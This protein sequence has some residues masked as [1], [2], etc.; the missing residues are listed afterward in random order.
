MYGVSDSHD[1]ELG[2]D[3]DL[4]EVMPAPGGKGAIRDEM[5]GTLVGIVRAGKRR[6]RS[7][8]TV[9]TAAKTA[10]AA[11]DA[12][13]PVRLFLDVFQGDVAKAAAWLNANEGRI[14]ARLQQGSVATSSVDDHQENGHAEAEQGREGEGDEGR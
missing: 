2:P 12:Q 4:N 8:Q 14:R 3:V 13:D 1:D 6:P 7:W 9:V 11:I 10:I 5:L